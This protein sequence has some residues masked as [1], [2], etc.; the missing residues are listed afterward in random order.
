M[1]KSMRDKQW[2]Q[3]LKQKAYTDGN[4]HA[5][6]GPIVPGDQVLLKNTRETGKLA[7]K[8]ETKSYT[9][10]T[11]EGHQVTVNSSEG[12]VYKRNSSSVK[13]YLLVSEL[14]PAT[15]LVPAN[16]KFEDRPGVVERPRSIIR[17]PERFKDYVLGK[18]RNDLKT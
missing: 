16:T 1:M 17:S 8:F 6:Q 5:V 9:V 13:P 15:E 11:R 12:A 14:E 3:K 4:R 18:P 2:E 10:L 7:P